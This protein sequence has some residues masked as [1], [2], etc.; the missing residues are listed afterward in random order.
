MMIAFAA[1]LF[2]CCIPAAIWLTALFAA[3][4]KEM[5]KLSK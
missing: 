5:S 1:M 2:V 4:I 3:G